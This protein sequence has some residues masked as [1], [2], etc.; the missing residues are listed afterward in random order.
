[1]YCIT[2]T[3]TAVKTW[4]TNWVSNHFLAV[5]VDSSITVSRLGSNLGKQASATHVPEQSS[6]ATARV[7]CPSRPDLLPP[8]LIEPCTDCMLSSYT[9]KLPW[10]VFSRAEERFAALDVL[11]DCFPK[12]LT[13]LD[14]SAQQLSSY[15]CTRPMHTLAELQPT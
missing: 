15:T 2:C 10:L 8:V 7:F 3:G 9:W 5:T 12:G 14:W 11:R 4:Q 6:S 13:W 1:M